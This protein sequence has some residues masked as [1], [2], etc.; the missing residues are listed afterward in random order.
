MGNKTLP[1]MEIFG[2]TI[3]GEGLLAGKRSHFIRLGGCGYKCTWCDSMHAVTPKLVKANAERMDAAEIVVNI[4]SIDAGGHS[5]W[6][7]ISGGDPTMHNLE[8]LVLALRAAGHKIAIECQGQFFHEWMT[9]CDLITISPKPPSSGMLDKFDI[10]VVSDI[11]KYCNSY[12]KVVIFNG[13]DL[14]WAID[15]HDSTR[16][17]AQMHL[18]VGTVLEAD[19]DKDVEIEAGICSDLRVLYEEALKVDDLHDVTILPQLHVLAWG[20]EQGK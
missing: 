12:L 11:L 16:H 9:L 4:E 3:Q 20:H 18:S 8:A 2:P 13:K 19:R 14:N 15:L 7:T 5:E 1:V 6:V 10:T 17:T